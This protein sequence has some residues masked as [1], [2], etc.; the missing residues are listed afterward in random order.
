MAVIPR[1]IDQYAVLFYVLGALGAFLYLWSAIQA[2]RRK[3]LALFTLEREDAANQS[4]R[5]W[6][7]AG[8]CVLLIAGVYSVSS[9]VVPNL[10]EEEAESTPLMAQL[11]TPTAAPTVPQPA[12]VTPGPTVTPRSVP[13]VAP[14]ATPLNSAPDTPVVSPTPE[15]GSGGMVGNAACTSAGTQIITPQNGDHVSGVIDVVGTASL[16]EFS[17]YKFEIQWPDTTEWVTV[18]SFEKP[19]AGGLLGTWDTRPLTE[20][21]GTYKFRLVVVD[22]TGNFPEPCVISVVV[23]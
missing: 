13:T 3:D 17:F 11:F 21:P 1:L 22:N 15:Q 9:F 4:R 14:I 7:M 18:Q 10:P 6:V 8:V 20:Q 5:A 19:V 12:T 23:E 2:H 16:P